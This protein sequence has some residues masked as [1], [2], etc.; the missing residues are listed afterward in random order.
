MRLCSINCKNKQTI[1]QNKDKLEETFKIS[2]VRVLK[3]TLT[4]DSNN[5]SAKVT[6]PTYP[7][8]SLIIDFM[9]IFFI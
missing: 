7:R 2:C 9:L 4:T 5:L 1:G 6:L 8:S 3:T